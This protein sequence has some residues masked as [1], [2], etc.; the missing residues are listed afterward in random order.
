MARP[1]EKDA[2]DKRMKV[3]DCVRDLLNE[4]NEEAGGTTRSADQLDS[5][6][7]DLEGALDEVESSDAHVEAGELPVPLAKVS[8]A[9]AR[10]DADTLPRKPC[11]E[12]QLFEGAPAPPQVLAEKGPPEDPY[13]AARRVLETPK[14]D[15]CELSLQEVALAKSYL[16]S[17]P[18][19]EARARSER[20]LASRIELANQLRLSEKQGAAEKGPERRAQKMLRRTVEKVET[21]QL[22]EL[23]LEELELISNSYALICKRIKREKNEE[24]LL[25]LLHSSM[26]RLESRCDTLRGSLAEQRAQREEDNGEQ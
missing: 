9:Q 19:D 3:A 6:I 4:T 15:L 17:L 25:K 1:G 12:E 13:T 5:I 21:Q 22:D 18:H 16:D 26:D 24:R 8:D 10:Q 20:S 11:V 23:T 2:A 14:D 7:S